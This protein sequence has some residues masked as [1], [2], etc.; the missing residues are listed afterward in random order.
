M[1]GKRRSYKNINKTS[2]HFC[3]SQMWGTFQFLYFYSSMKTIGVKMF[4]LLLMSFNFSA[5]TVFMSPLTGLLKIQTSMMF[6]II[7]CSAYFT[8]TQARSYVNK[9]FFTAITDS[10]TVQWFDN[11]V[12]V[13]KWSFR[14]FVMNDSSNDF[15]YFFIFY[16]FIIND[17]KS[18]TMTFKN[19]SVKTYMQLSK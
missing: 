9:E 15:N 2:S 12:A 14:S 5:W 11:H 7:L 17:T 10:E 3:W 19:M 16:L 8:S 1:C 18:Y 13:V 4:L 6:E